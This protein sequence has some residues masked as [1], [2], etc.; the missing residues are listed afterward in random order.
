M[1]YIWPIIM[2]SSSED[3]RMPSTGM[4]TTPRASNTPGSN[5]Q[6]TTTASK[7][8]ASALMIRSTAP[9]VHFM[10]LYR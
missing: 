9:S 2:H 1:E 5:V 7:P 3:S 8:S 6:D 10:V 4:S